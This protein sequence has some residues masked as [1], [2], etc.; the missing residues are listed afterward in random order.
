MWRESEI[1]RR[2]TARAVAAD[3]MRRRAL[4]QGCSADD[5][6]KLAARAGRLALQQESGARA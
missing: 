4:A 1:I 6:E 3:D 5:A 2:R